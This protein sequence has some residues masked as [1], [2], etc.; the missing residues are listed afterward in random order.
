MGKHSLEEMCVKSSQRCPC[1]LLST[2]AW[3]HN[4]GAF[5]SA[6]D[7]VKSPSLD[8]GCL[9]PGDSAP[10]THWNSCSQT[11]RLRGRKIHSRNGN[12]TPFPQLS[13]SYPNHY[14]DWATPPPITYNNLFVEC[15]FNVEF[16]TERRPG[17]VAVL[18]VH[19]VTVWSGASHRHRC[20]LCCGINRGHLPSSRVI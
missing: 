11:G 8:S 15:G 14:T 20:L 17:Q 9:T 5:I 12:G 16:L 3:R 4:I 2:A 1:D 18:N 6:S 7:V 19:N 10:D 13:S